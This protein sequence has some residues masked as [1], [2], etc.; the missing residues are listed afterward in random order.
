M[1]LEFVSERPHKRREL[2][3]RDG[4]SAVITAMEEIGWE[5]F[6]HPDFGTMMYKNGSGPF[7]SWTSKE[8]KV[9]RKEAEKALKAIGHAKVPYRKL[10]CQDFG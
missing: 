5:K 9:F 8:E 6:R 3:I 1:L 7:N 2:I 10:N 4:D